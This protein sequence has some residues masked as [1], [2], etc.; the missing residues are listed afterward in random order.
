LD[1]GHAERQS[2]GRR[3]AGW[4]AEL[5]HG[6]PNVA[7]SIALAIDGEVRAGVVHA[8]FLDQTFTAAKGHGAFL[9]GWQ[10]IF[11]ESRGLAESLISTGFPH[12]RSDLAPAI[13]SGRSSYGIAGNRYLLGRLRHLRY[14]YRN[15]RAVGCCGSRACRKE[16]RRTADESYCGD[17]SIYARPVGQRCIVFNAV[18]HLGTEDASREER[19]GV[20]VKVSATRS[21]PV[22]FFL[23]QMQFGKCAVAGRT[24]GAHRSV[25][26]ASASARFLRSRRSWTGRSMTIAG[27]E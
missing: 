16:S 6:H 13:D 15:A 14:S 1:R 17:R 22:V 4:H 25:H 2:L 20:E 26:T 5:C 24:G 12:D 3:S 7:A 21:Q 18:N 27:T 11:R 9:N 19:C 10:I 8:P 23:R